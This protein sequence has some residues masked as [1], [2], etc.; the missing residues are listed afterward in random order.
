V[1]KGVF[2][3]YRRGKRK[4]RNN[5]ILIRIEGINNRKEAARFI[6]REVV[7]KNPKGT[8]LRGKVVGVHGRG[9]T[10]KASFKKSLP[11]QAIGSELTIG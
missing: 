11:G 7:W 5:Q 3:S 2:V 4:Q 9:G 1:D 8:S 10:L 6:G